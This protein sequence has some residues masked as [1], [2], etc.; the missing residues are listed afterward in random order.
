M[1][2]RPGHKLSLLHKNGIKIIPSSDNYKYKI[3][4]TINGELVKQSGIKEY[5][6][7]EVWDKREEIEEHYFQ[8]LIQVK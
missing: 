3:R 5:S 7:K 2:N 1:N 6:K 8:K 4:V